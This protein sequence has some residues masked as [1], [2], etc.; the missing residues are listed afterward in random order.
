[1]ESTEPSN[2]KTATQ[3][4]SDES[5]A[6]KAE[7]NPL[8]PVAPFSPKSQPPKTHYDVTCRP[9][10][11]WWEKRKPL[12]EIIGVILLGVYTI[13]TAYMYYA[14][15]DAANAAESAANTASINLAQSQATF[16]NEQRPYLIADGI[17]AF[18]EPL[19][20]EK[21]INV[22]VS[23]KNIGK[24]PAIKVIANFRLVKFYPGGKGAAGRSKFVRFIDAAFASL[25]KEDAEGREERREYASAEQDMA[26]NQPFWG[27]TQDK[28]T[29]TGDEIK[30]SLSTGAV[31]LY[32]VGLITYT[33]SA[34]GTYRTQACYFFFGSDPR[35]WHMCD[36][37]NI[38][39]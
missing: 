21:P 5:D 1:M 33:D 19:A 16:K 18:V 4:T 3:N 25:N 35:V 30:E 38:I 6:E 2:D 13:Y 26:P 9:E 36:V 39:K 8:S 15:R 22:N 27:T 24:I 23:Y 31:S 29:L 10:K 7:S 37:Y 34:L 28:V 11:D 32:C 20:P 12:V 17:P 14:N